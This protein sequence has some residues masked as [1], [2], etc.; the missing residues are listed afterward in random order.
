MRRLTHNRRPAFLYPDSLKELD[1]YRIPINRKIAEDVERVQYLNRENCNY[2]H[3]PADSD[4]VVI[5]LHG[6]AWVGGDASELL[7]LKDLFSE[8]HVVCAGYTRLTDEPYTMEGCVSSI[9]EL[10]DH[11]KFNICENIYLIGHSAGGHLAAYCSTQRELAGVGII[12]APLLLHN[13]SIRRN[14]GVQYPDQDFSPY[15]PGHNKPLTDNI[16]FLRGDH[17]FHL[18]EHIATLKQDWG[19]PVKYVV[20]YDTDHFNILMSILEKTKTYKAIKELID[21][22]ST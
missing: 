14:M 16:L 8:H 1:E 18:H 21:G 5:L 9:I 12:S 15:Y 3:F 7:F 20:P 6:G 2:F 17:E 13:S 22:Q 10:I 19:V 4:K 11:V